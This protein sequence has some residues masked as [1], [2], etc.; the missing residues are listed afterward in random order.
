MQVG[1]YASALAVEDLLKKY[2]KQYPITVE[3]KEDS[4]GVKYIVF[5]G[6]L[7]KDELGAIQERFKSFGF[8]DC[9]LK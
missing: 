7:K 5:V 2:S 3:K 6:P 1:V 9:F 8:K 4:T